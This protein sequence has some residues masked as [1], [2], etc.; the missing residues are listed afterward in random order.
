MNADFHRRVAIRIV[1]EI[2]RHAFERASRHVKDGSRD[3]AWIDDLRPRCRKKRG[4]RA[5][6]PKI[7][8]FEKLDQVVAIG[9]KPENAGGPE[10]MDELSER[11]FAVLAVADDLGQQW[12]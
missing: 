9:L 6:F 7:I 3:T 11:G 5:A 1:T 2:R 8:A 10:G 12:V 4:G